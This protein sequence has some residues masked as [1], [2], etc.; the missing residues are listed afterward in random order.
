[1]AH[2]RSPLVV[3]RT[4]VPQLMQGPGGAPDSM[5]VLAVADGVTGGG[6]GATA[7]MVAVETLA[8]V[9]ADGWPRAQQAATTAG[10]RQPAASIPTLREELTKAF[11]EGNLRI[12]Q[13]ASQGP[14]PR[15]SLLSR[16]AQLPHGDEPMTG[17]RR[18]L[19]QKKRC[20]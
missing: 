4:S 7:S 3:S 19:S 14:S 17:H 6:G 2:L 10:A 1:V 16:C 11:E 15:M 8:N 18:T 9:L 20:A 12:Q 5:T 13:A